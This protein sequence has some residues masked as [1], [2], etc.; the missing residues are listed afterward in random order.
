M[1]NYNSS[2]EIENLP[3]STKEEVHQSR[4]RI[5]Y[6]VYLSN[7]FK[8]F[9]L[10]DDEE[11]EDVL[12]NYRIWPEPAEDE[13]INSILTPRMAQ[14]P[15]VMKAAGRNWAT[16]TDEL[17]NGWRSRAA[18]LNLRPQND[19]K[20][21]TIPSSIN[22]NL[23]DNILA[24]L[25]TDWAMFVSVMRSCVMRNRKNGNSQKEYTFGLERIKLNSQIY[26][27]F[28]MNDLMKI[29]IFGSYPNF[30][31]LHPHEI[32]HRTKNE[33]LFNFSSYKRMNELF[34]FGGISGCSHTKDGR[35]FI[36]CAKVSLS[37]ITGK[38]INGYVF[39]ETNETLKIWIEGK[40]RDEMIVIDRPEFCQELGMY[41]LGT[42]NEDGWSIIQYWPV[43]FKLRKKSGQISFTI[44]RSY[45]DVNDNIIHTIYI[46]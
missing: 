4:K 19:G 18:E 28:H 14:V 15:D 24:A 8:Q 44:N 33:V 40:G 31:F 25:S 45:Y 20:F 30:S 46:G 26:R 35:V 6:H 32:V 36:C 41:E 1:N 3:L 9:S 10:L 38:V 5:G 13:S 29:T 27:S 11:K 42:D 22:T 23:Q 21:T 37:N 2:N 16:L 7:F 39:D 12:V 34:S 43:R 17:K